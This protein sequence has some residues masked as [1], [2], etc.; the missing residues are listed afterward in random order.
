[1]TDYEELRSIGNEIA[2]SVGTEVAERRSGGF[3]WST[4]SSTS[5]AVTEIDTWA[6]DEIVRRITEKRP[7]DGLLGEEGTSTPGSTGVV[8]VIDPIDGTTNFL[9]DIPG[10]GISI[11]VQVDGA[12]VAG[13]VF[14]PVRLELFSAALGQGATRNGQPISPSSANDLST[15]LVITGFSYQAEMR[16]EQARILETVLPAVR[17]IRR[18]GGAAL[19]LCAI[20]S[21]RADA[22]YERGLSPWD[23]IAGALIAREAG[24]IVDVGELTWASAPGI[25]DAFQSLL[26]RAQA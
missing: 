23:S 12:A 26:E 18:L 17:D 4:K 22:S 11:G 21:G 20:A 3:V 13:A 25:A 14:D 16:R 5:A 10:Y 6:E 8:W 15:A 24:A 1:M 9:Y 19:D 2:E 7:R